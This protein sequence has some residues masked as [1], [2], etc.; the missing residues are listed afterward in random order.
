MKLLRIALALAAVVLVAGCSST[1]RNVPVGDDVRTLA[2]DGAS[3][4]ESIAAADDLYREALTHYVT[5]ELDRARPLLRQALAELG[6]AHPS[7]TSL[8]AHKSSLTSRVE[9]FLDAI[10][11]RDSA[12]ADVPPTEPARLDTIPVSVIRPT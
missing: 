1:S 5:D 10:E 9:Y 7:D 11:S 8:R 12:S 2:Q 6:D 3:A 4:A